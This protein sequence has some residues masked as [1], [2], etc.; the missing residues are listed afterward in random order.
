MLGLRADQ[1]IGNLGSSRWLEAIWEPGARLYTLPNGL[2]MVDVTGD[3][4]ARLIC[5]DLGIL[6]GN[7][8]KVATVYCFETTGDT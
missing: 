4:D 6:G 3:G 5:T 8:T 1:N 2:D 7:S